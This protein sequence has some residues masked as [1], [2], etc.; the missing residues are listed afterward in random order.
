V[1]AEELAELLLLLDGIVDPQDRRRRQEQL[2]DAQSTRV[3]CVAL[4]ILEQRRDQEI[5]EPAK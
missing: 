1:T 5:S 4:E 3:A 2:L